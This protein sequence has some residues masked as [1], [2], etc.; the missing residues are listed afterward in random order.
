MNL[1]IEQMREIVDGAPELSPIYDLEQ[2][3]YIDRE[4]VSIAM[5][6]LKERFLWI[7]NLKAKIDQHYYGQSEE[8][9]LEQYA[10]LSQEK[11]EGGAVLVGSFKG[12]NQWMVDQGFNAIRHANCCRI[13]YE[14]GQQSQKAEVD[15]LKEM[16]QRYIGKMQEQQDQIAELKAQKERLQ[17]RFN[18]LLDKNI[19]DE[20]THASLKLRVMRVSHLM[21]KAAENGTECVDIGSLYDALIKDGD[22]DQ[23]LRGASDQ[24]LNR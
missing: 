7:S 17:K 11:I 18:F 2:K 8:K 14:G 1:T 13:A 15:H 24:H 19:R 16:N 12:F 20:S 4:D 21:D 23:S 9:E 6:F 3:K 5:G 10:V 22:L